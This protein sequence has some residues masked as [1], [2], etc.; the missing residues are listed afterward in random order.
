MIVEEIS[1]MGKMSPF[2][3]FKEQ[4]QVCN[5]NSLNHIHTN[6]KPKKPKNKKS[7]EGEEFL[8][9]WDPDEEKQEDCNFYFCLTPEKTEEVKMVCS[10]SY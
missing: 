3:P 4:C 1:F 9:V 7:F 6:Q 2:E 5:S 8:F 10:Y